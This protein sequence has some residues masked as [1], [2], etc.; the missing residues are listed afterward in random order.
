[1]LKLK[2]LS[3]LPRRRTLRRYR[4]VMHEQIAAEPSVRLLNRLLSLPLGVAPLPDPAAVLAQHG[5]LALYGPPAGGRTLALLQTAAR[6][7]ASGADAPVFYLALAEVDVPNLS[8]RAVVA[9]AVHQA[10]LPTT[11]AEGTWPCLLLIDDWELLPPARRALWQQFL[12]VTAPQWPAMRAVVALPASTPWP[13]LVALQ[14]AAP[15]AAQA[16]AILAHLLPDHDYTAILAALRNLPDLGAAPSL[17]DLALLALTYSLGG[18]PASR[19]QLYA[20]AF[21]LVQPLIEE[22]RQQALPGA[23]LEDSHGA[24]LTLCNG[25][26]IG[27]ALLRHYRLARAF[28]GG[29]DLETLVDLSAEERAAVAPLAAGLLDDPSPVLA[30]LWASGPDDASLRALAACAREV[31]A[32]APAYGLR[33]LDRLLGAEALPAYAALLV[34]L[35]PTLPDLLAAASRCQEPRALAALVALANA[36][37]QPRPLWLALL[38]HPAA[39]P[40]LRWAVADCLIAEPPSAEQLGAAPAA[41]PADLAP[42][43]Y[44]AALG[45]SETRAALAAPPLRAAVPVLLACPAAGARRTAAAALILA[46]PALPAELRALAVA[47]V[48]SRPLI[49]RAAGDPAPALRQAA[50]AALTQGEPIL[51]LAALGRVLDLPAAAPEARIATIDAIAAVAHQSA[52]AILI[53]AAI[54]ADL[55]L[56]ARLHAVER[57]ARRADGEALMLR[58]LLATTALPTALRAAAARHLGRRGVGAALPDLAAILAGPGAPLLRRATAR[59]LGNLGQRLALRE[60]AVAALIAGLRRA[61]TDPVLGECIAVALGQSGAPAA[62]APLAALLDPRLPALL[63]AAWQRAA[64]ALAHAPAEAWP[65]LRLPEAL[66]LGLLDALAAGGTLA[67]PPSR[68][69]ELV[70]HQALRLAAAAAAALTELGAAP[71]LR[72]P[73]VERLRQALHAERRAEVIR[74]LLQALGHLSNPAVELAAIFAA[75]AAAPELRW[76]ALEAL[77]VDPRA[78]D[79]LLRRLD[80]GADEPFVQAMIV[81][82]LG[83]LDADAALPTLRRLARDPA[84]DPLLRAATVAAV[85][86]SAAPEAS[87]LLVALAADSAAPLALRVRAA[88]ALPATLRAEAQIALRQALRADHP[89]PALSAALWR[90]LARAGD[91]AALAQLLRAAQSGEGP[92]ALASIESL[93]ALDDPSLAPLLVRLSQSAPSHAGL[94]LTAVIALLRVGGD[95]YLSLLHEY[96]AAESPSLRMQAHAALARLRPADPRLGAPLAD[97]GAP[98]PLRLQALAH[99][100]AHDPAAP[101]PARSVAAAAEHPQVRLAAASALATSACPDAVASLAAVLAPAAAPAALVLCRRCCATLGAIA[102]GSGASAAAARELLSRLALDPGQSPAHRHWA[103]EAL[104][105]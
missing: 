26:T 92:E 27:R 5:S 87:E 55:P 78:L 35:V 31:P 85:A 57:L 11:Y 53:R 80:Q 99:L 30:A 28:A 66:H 22:Q 32:R 103:A 43:A 44:L 97:P 3:F 60:A 12:T 52:A 98:L 6:W 65:E 16:G 7:A 96:L 68:L 67:D 18:M 20:H 33:L 70:A 1:M 75:P 104:L 77:G 62:L 54:T 73:V 89:P 17:A 58:R 61:A 38:D 76:L 19:A 4:A 15:D 51:A 93:A 102:H 2:T 63:H 13:T 45:S 90:A 72:M 8:P 21:A 94:R 29:H 79:L 100:V 88:E 74:A 49:E 71:E 91:S 48:D 83:A 50:L 81:T 23:Q 41:A 40:A 14:I 59:A 37:P 82:A 10:G 69:E 42:R 24:H 46:D 47:A 105:A 34:D 56:E 84:G 39:T 86:R 95:E 9:A 36:M 25:L 101:L 64:P